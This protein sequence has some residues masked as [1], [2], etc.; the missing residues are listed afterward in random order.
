[1]HCIANKVQ[2]GLLLVNDCNQI[3]T[4][5]NIR[6]RL[7]IDFVLKNNAFGCWRTFGLRRSDENLGVLLGQWHI[8]F[9]LSWRDYDGISGSGKFASY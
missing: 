2:I 4:V 8:Q 6:R 5:V 7:L 3:V 1:M 9:S